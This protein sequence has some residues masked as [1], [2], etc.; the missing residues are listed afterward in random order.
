[1]SELQF[2]F[3]MYNPETDI[4]E[5]NTGTDSVLFIRCIDFNSKVIFDDP[6]NVVYL[7]HLAKEQP[8]TYAKFALSDNRLQD[9]VDAMNWFN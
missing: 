1:M 6:N 2:Q 7:Y 8:L 9:Y 3:A 5:V 4:V